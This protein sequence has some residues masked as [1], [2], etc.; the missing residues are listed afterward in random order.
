MISSIVFLVLGGVFIMK[1]I[2]GIFTLLG[3]DH[4]KTPLDGSMMFSLFK[5]P[6]LCFVLLMVYAIWGIPFLEA[7]N[8]E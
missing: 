4:S 7:N 2:K 8:Y 3:T 6:L 5:I 1:T